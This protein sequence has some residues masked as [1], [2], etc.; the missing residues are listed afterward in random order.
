MRIDSWLKIGLNDGM[1]KEQLKAQMTVP[2]PE[3]LTREKMGFSTEGVRRFEALY[4]EHGDELWVPRGV[5]NRYL[6][7]CDV[8]DD[9][10]CGSPVDFRSRIVLRDGTGEGE[11]QRD[12]VDTLENA[13]RNTYGACGQAAPG[14]GKTITTLEVAARLKVTALVL[15]HKEFLLDQWRD[16]ILQCF[17][18]SPDDIGYV[19]QDTCDF[20]GKKIVIALVQSLLA[21]EYPEELYTWPGMLIVDEVHRFAAPTFRTAIVK[22]PAR[23]RLGITAT[24]KRQDG[25]E[26]VFFTHIGDITAV[27][28][29]RKIVPTIN[30]VKTNVLVASE[31]PFKDYRGKISFVKVVSWLAEHDARNRQLARM[32]VQAI[33]ADRKILLLSARREH[34]VTL[35]KLVEIECERVGVRTTIGYYVGGLTAEQRAIS[36]TRQ[37][38]LGTYSMAREGLDVPDLDTLFLATPQKDIVQAVGR[39]LREFKGKKAPLVIDLV[40]PISICHGLAKARMREYKNMGWKVK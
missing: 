23:Y 15:V 8:Q 3:Y 19:Q 25:L 12:F 27:G 7:T 6:A 35:K 2:N 39:I 26:R 14:Y 1:N 17:D 21:R 29:K 38:M 33:Q 5:V 16:R 37:V 36:E 9:T 22:F 10:C 28:E 24:P 4:E 34:L 32:I 40:D 30:M 11:D 31:R 13:M 20:E 18:I